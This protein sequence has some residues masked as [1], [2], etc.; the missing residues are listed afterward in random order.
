MQETPPDLVLLDVMMPG[1][2][3]Y[4]LT[5][6]IRRDPLLSSIPVVLIT[7]HLEVCRIKGL[8]VGATDFLRKPV[9][10]EL[11]NLTIQNL[12]TARKRT[13]ALRQIN[14]MLRVQTELLSWS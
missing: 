1:I 8:A 13:V 2:D 7:A 11:L 6:K 9:D 4:D 14:R 3:G 12:V 5:R 10:F